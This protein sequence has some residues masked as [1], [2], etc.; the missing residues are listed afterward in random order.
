[1]TTAAAA[2]GV[3]RALLEANKPSALTA[4]RWQ[5]E[6]E[7]SNGNLILPDEPAAFA[8]TEFLASPSS[9]IEIGGGR[10]ANRHRNSAHVDVYVF[11]PRG[12]GMVV[13]NAQ[14]VGCLDIAEQIAALFRPLRSGGVS[15]DDVTVYP[16]GNGSDLKP[17]G[18]ASEVGNYFW[19]AVGVSLHFDLTG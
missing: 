19:A 11:V 17:P 3:I 1:M 4:L 6:F 12:T 15:V 14:S 7:D 9:V 18:L 13:T 10:G 8:Y 5:N 16:G 2:Y